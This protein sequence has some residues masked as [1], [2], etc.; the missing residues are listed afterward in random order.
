[1]LSG[2]TGNR[3]LLF[4]GRLL[5]LQLRHDVAAS[6]HRADVLPTVRVFGIDLRINRI[7]DLILFI[8]KSMPFMLN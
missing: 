4:R 7:S 6:H 8:L 1:M 5:V 3:E 2:L